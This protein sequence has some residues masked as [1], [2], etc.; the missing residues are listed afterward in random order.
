MKHRQGESQVNSL[1]AL[2]PVLSL[3][4]MDPSHVRT[5]L[6]RFAQLHWGFSIYEAAE[7]NFHSLRDADG[8]E[9]FLYEVQVK[10][11]SSLFL[12]FIFV[13]Y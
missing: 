9:V 4:N 13:L 3:L 12:Q 2:A 5:S 1:S 10:A 8:K 6:A 7:L 11:K